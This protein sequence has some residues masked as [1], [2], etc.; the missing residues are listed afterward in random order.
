MRQGPLWRRR[1]LS[2][3]ARLSAQEPGSLL[4]LATARIRLLYRCGGD[5]Q[6][7]SRVL[8]ALA[9]RALEELS[10]RTVDL[11]SCS[12]HSLWTSLRDGYH[13]LDRSACL[14]EAGLAD[15]SPKAPSP[16]PIHSVHI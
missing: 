6:H 11:Y 4:P 15:D 16:G 5:P 8:R 1:R 10:F 2:G 7:S 14:S 13:T 9:L 3:A 12:C